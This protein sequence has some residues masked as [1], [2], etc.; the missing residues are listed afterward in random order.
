MVALC[1]LSGAV[2][3]TLAQDR[4]PGAGSV[5]VGFLRDMRSHHEGAI[6][7][8]QVEL[9]RGT[10][11][12]IRTFADEIMR[13][14]SYEI[15]LMDRMQLDWGHRPEDRP[16]EAMT[17][18][19]DPVAVDAMPG[20]ASDEE[21]EL[22][23][24]GAAPDADVRELAA[25]MA[26]VQRAEIGEMAAAAERAGLDGRPAGVTFDAYDPATGELGGHSDH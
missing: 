6:V 7:L 12:G 5:D 24:R 11:P 16:D 18:M 14:Q 26:A 4:P 23:E 25:R 10:E 19:G 13:F 2:G 17:W 8:S 9:A 22:L 20:M 15:G 21:L 1:F 3:W